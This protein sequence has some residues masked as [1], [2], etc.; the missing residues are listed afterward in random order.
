[1]IVEGVRNFHPLTYVYDNDL[2]PLSPSQ[3]VI[4]KRLLTNSNIGTTREQLHDRKAIT[5]QEKLTKDSKP[6]LE[7]LVLQ[8]FGSITDKRKTAEK[9]EMLLVFTKT[10]F[11][12]IYG[13]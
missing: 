3:L 8:N 11:L 2:Q 9:L 5:K 13:N 10:R 12:V 6:L 4:G 1:M 7:S